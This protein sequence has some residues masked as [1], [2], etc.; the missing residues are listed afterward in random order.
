MDKEIMVHIHNGILF[1]I[2]INVFESVT[3]RWMILE[4]I[5]QSEISQKDKEKYCI[6]M[7][8]YGI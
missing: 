1:T 3:M 2:K 5:T 7:H 6:L 8:I 4:P